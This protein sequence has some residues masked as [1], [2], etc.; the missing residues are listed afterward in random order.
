MDNVIQRDVGRVSS[1]S[2]RTMS[3][4]KMMLHAKIVQKIALQKML[5]TAPSTVQQTTL[6]PNS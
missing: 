1:R 3:G 5:P 2:L 6:S 4:G